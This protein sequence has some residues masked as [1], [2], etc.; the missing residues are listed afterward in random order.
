MARYGS[1]TPSAAGAASA[2][3]TAAKA[4]APTPAPAKP[5]G[6]TAPAARTSPP[7]T[8]ASKTSA[9]P[10]SAESQEVF[11]TTPGKL[12]IEERFSPGQAQSLYEAKLLSP[13][14]TAALGA[15]EADT[16]FYL[17]KLEDVARLRKEGAIGRPSMLS[18]ATSAVT[19]L[20]GAPGAM[21]T[22][23]VL[24]GGA[25]AL[26]NANVTL[27][28]GAPGLVQAA[29]YLQPERIPASAKMPMEVPLVPGEPPTKVMPDARL[30]VS[31]D[32][33]MNRVADFR[34]LVTEVGAEYRQ[35]ADAVRRGTQQ[36]MSAMRDEDFDRNQLPRLRAEQ[37]ERV[38]QLATS[39]ASLRELGFNDDKEVEARFNK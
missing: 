38:R 19:K 8:P 26:R 39:R 18:A 2:A 14:D 24:A 20:A 13:A 10:Y 22:A 29:Q 16:D 33:S 21:T 12:S 3:T 7:K 31:P 34:R 4:A 1:L 11:G 32:K 25:E 28:G 30:V 37:L 5:A 23:R 27:R 35:D 9:S 36:L 17:K 15:K 6:S